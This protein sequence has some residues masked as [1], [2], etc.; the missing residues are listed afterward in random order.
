MKIHQYPRIPTKSCT[1]EAA[2]S[3]W[4][5]RPQELSPGAWPSVC[6]EC[7]HICK[8]EPGPPTG[9]QLRGLSRLRAVKALQ[10]EVLLKGQQQA[11]CICRV[12]LLPGLCCC[13]ACCCCMSAPHSAGKGGRPGLQGHREVGMGV[14][15]TGPAGAETFPG[16]RLSAHRQSQPSY[17]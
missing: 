6:L 7:F 2:G 4:G 16:K 12:P 3:V 5:N 11:F 10:E 8:V 9:G 14:I 15:L 17:T 13:T 1:W